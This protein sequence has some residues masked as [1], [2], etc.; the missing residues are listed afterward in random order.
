MGDPRLSFR[1]IVSKGLSANSPASGPH[2]LASKNSRSRR[3][4][5]S[6]RAPARS[7]SESSQPNKRSN[8]ASSSRSMLFPEG[9]RRK[10]YDGPSGIFQR[11]TGRCE[12]GEEEE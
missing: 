7:L 1:S 5:F 10:N 6:Y 2:P 12:D 3:R 9:N 8:A 11:V 4:R